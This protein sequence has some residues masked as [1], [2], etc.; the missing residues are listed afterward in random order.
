MNKKLIV[1]ATGNLHKLK[2]VNMMLESTPYIAKAMSDFD[3]D[4]DIVEDGSTMH[5]N[6]KIKS[7]FLFE[8][9]KVSAMGEDSGLEIKAL[10][11]SPGIYTAR[12]AGKQRNDFDNMNKVLQELEGVKDR[13][14]QFRSVISLNI[15]NETYFFEGIVEGRIG[16]EIKGDGGFGYDPIFIPTGFDQSFAELGSE[17]KN[18]FSHRAKAVSKM[19]DFLKSID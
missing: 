2:E 13:T 7:D 17:M 10:N 5:E 11:M 3:I 8:K 18:Q 4:E 12:Y 9:L 16:A 15:N 14:A 6:A 19:V 1:F